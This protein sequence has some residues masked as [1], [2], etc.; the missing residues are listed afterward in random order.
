MIFGGLRLLLRAE[1]VKKRSL[2]TLTAVAGLL[3]LTVLIF[4]AFY[5]PQRTANPEFA[6][7]TTVHAVRVDYRDM[8]NS[9]D[10]VDG[11]EAHLQ[12]AGVNLVA[13][14]AGRADWSYFPWSNHQ[15]R[16]SSDVKITGEDYLLDDSSRFGKWAHVSAVVDVLA[17]R[18]LEL[19][20]EK[21]A[22]S[23]LGKP[24]QNLVG[25]MELV[26]GSFSRDLLDMITAIATFYPVNSITLSELVYY[27]DGYGEE[28]K[29]AYLAYT[30][31][32]DWPRRADGRINIDD[33][34]IG[35]WRSY[36][37]DRFL[38]K[39][40]A[41][42]HAQGKQLFVEARIGLTPDGDVTVSN[43]TDLGLL[44]QHAD[45]VIVWGNHDLDGRSQQALAAVAK[46]LAHFGRGRAILSIGLWDK[47][48][49][50]DVPN[51]QMTSI[52]AQ[53]FRTALKSAGQGGA[54]DLW[55]TPSFLLSEDDWQALKA[56]WNP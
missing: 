35:T 41:I 32:T 45:R 50:P 53:E 47:N 17:P 19:H 1:S 27:V 30:G 8:S 39:A 26:D 5:H 55:I 6:S 12:M 56:Q 29:A 15:D 22:I 43:G 24:S 2:P 14:G 49:D 13:V 42:V 33:P 21:A 4:L 44:L 7:L 46:Y 11:L 37:I 10:E 20:P 52:S 31:K 23:W 38:D 3:A 25:T 36:E 34:S 9:R 18:Y 54:T 51:A 28:D 40:T 48:Y 16:W